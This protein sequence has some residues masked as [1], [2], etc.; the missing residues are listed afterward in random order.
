MG[1][2]MGAI[3]RSAVLFD[4]EAEN[5]IAHTI[6]LA[7][8]RFGRSPLSKTGKT[9]SGKTLLSSPPVDFFTVQDRV[10]IKLTDVKVCDDRKNMMDFHTCMNTD[11]KMLFMPFDDAIR[12]TVDYVF[13]HG[14]TLASHCI[15]NDLAFLAKT[16]ERVNSKNPMVSR[17]IVADPKHGINDHRWN[18][19][20]LVCTQFLACTK[21]ENFMKA[22]VASKPEKTTSKQFYQTSLESLCRLF[23]TIGKDLDSETNE[24]IANASSKDEVVKQVKLSTSRKLEI[25]ELNNNLLLP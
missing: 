10:V 9:R 22:Y 4:V 11:F 13:H 20:N 2:G 24:R 15:I 8:T 19:F 23:T 7:S 21:A 5:N 6:A 14:G 25:V 1:L 3:S 18:G 17:N 12:Y 16:Q